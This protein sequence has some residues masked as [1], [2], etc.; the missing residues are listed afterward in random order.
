MTNEKHFLKTIRQWEL[1]YGLFTNLPRIVKFT[2]FSPSSFKLKRGILPLLTK[3]VSQLGN[4]LSYQ[5]KIFLWTW[6]LKN[7]LLAKY[8]ISA[9]APLSNFLI[10]QQKEK[11]WQKQ[12]KQA[13][14]IC[15]FVHGI[16]INPLQ[17]STIIW[18]WGWKKA[19]VTNFL[20]LRIH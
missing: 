7:L 1:D 18:K 16:Y 6:L 9:A 11:W 20:F 3:Y 14:N 12:K 2:N 15:K 5:A 19:F 4:Y 13:Y 17:I 8:L 10:R